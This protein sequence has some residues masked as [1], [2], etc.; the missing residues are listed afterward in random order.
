[1]QGRFLMTFEYVVNVDVGLSHYVQTGHSEKPP[2]AQAGLVKFNTRCSTENCGSNGSGSK[3]DDS[4]NPKRIE[5]DL[6]NRSFSQGVMTNRYCMTVGSS[7][8]HVI[9]A[10]TLNLRMVRALHR[11]AQDLAQRVIRTS[12]PRSC[13]APHIHPWP[14]CNGFQVKELSQNTGVVEISNH[15]PWMT[16]QQIA[17]DSRLRTM[18]HTV[19]WVN[20]LCR[21]LSLKTPL[22]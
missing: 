3:Y 10:E 9:S 6:E 21:T 14:T 15:R 2:Q 16:G 17:Q 22:C 13:G 1:M 7:I 19:T 8:F 5:N 11:L 18:P 20:D 4:S 12:T